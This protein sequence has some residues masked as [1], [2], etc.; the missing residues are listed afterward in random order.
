L[1]ITAS[2]TAPSSMAALQQAFQVLAA[3][4][5]DARRLD[6]RVVGLA[7]RQRRRLACKADGAR[8]IRIPHHLER[9]ELAAELLARLPQQRAHRVER[10]QRAQRDG[11]RARLRCESQHGTRDDAEHAFAADEQLLEVDA[12]VVLDQGPQAIEHGAVG[13]HRF[14]PH[15]QFARHAVADHAVAAGVGRDVAAD[16]ATAARSEVQREHQP[17]RVELLLQRL[18]H[19]PGLHRGHAGVGVDALDCVHALQR[20]DDLAGL[21]Q[22]R[23]HEAGAAALRH[24]RDVRRVAEREGARYLGRVRRAQHRQRGLAAPALDVHEVAL[25]HVG[26]GHEATRPEFLLQRT[27]RVVHVHDVSPRLVAAVAMGSILP[28]TPAGALRAFR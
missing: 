18:Q 13:Q 17:L 22:V 28:R 25:V 3:A 6:Q 24:D 21:R 2:T 10:R 19:D 27:Q 15:H 9:R 12:G 14:Q 16:R 11:A 5:V 4:G 20:Q 26:R 23:Q 8:E 7:D 1:A